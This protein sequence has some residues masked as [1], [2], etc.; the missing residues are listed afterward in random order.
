[1]KNHSILPHSF[2]F[3][4]A[5]AGAL[6]ILGLLACTEEKKPDIPTPTPDPTSTA[7]N[8]EAKDYGQYTELIWS[9]EFNG[10]G[11][12]D[13]TK[14]TAE[15]GGSGWGNNELQYYTTSTENAY[16]VGG[17]LIIE[18][19]KQ[20]MEGRNYTSARLITKGKRSFQ[21]GRIDVR[22]K[23]PKGQGIWPAIWMLG[24]DIDQNNWPACGEIDIM[25]LR[26]QEPNKILSTMHYGSSTATHQYKGSETTLANGSFADDFH[27]FS[28]VRSKDKIRSYVDGREFYAF[29]TSDTAPYAYPF[30]NPFFVILN[31]A[32]GG[33]FLGNPS[34]TVIDTTPFPQQMMV[35][36]VRFYQYK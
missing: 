10:S 18:A 17:N 29:T 7:S 4:K 30:N 20:S 11:A 14:W 13:G 22:A 1:M 27:I 35:D 21:F 2:R 15:T 8:A 3:R 32:V 23:L 16:M 26:G 12:I 28:V 33:N 9:D 24:S 6:L 25:E 19:K 34:T 36:Y 31:V 5:G